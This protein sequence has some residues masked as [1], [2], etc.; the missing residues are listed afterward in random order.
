MD[1]GGARRRAKPRVR[2]AMD[3]PSVQPGEQHVLAPLLP[4]AARDLDRHVHLAPLHRGAA[5]GLRDDVRAPP[6]DDPA[7]AGLVREQL[8][9][10]GHGH[11]LLARLL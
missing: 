9:A 7:R 5:Q 8:H 2:V 6:G 10:R 3:A 4:R 1:E 11:P